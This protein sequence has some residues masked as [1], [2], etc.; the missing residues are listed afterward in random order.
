MAKSKELK[1]KEAEYREYRGKIV[2]FWRCA[3]RRFDVTTDDDE[4]AC[5]A[6][7]QALTDLQLHNIK[8]CCSE[9]HELATQRLEDPF[10]SYVDVQGLC[11]FY[12]LHK[13][14]WYS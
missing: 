3:L 11:V 7:E 10:A 6:I 8:K 12:N 14:N 5:K 4:Q 9:M 1:R 13:T 2:D